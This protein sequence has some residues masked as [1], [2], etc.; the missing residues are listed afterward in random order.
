MDINNVTEVS[1]VETVVAQIFD[2]DVTIST[3]INYGAD[4]TDYME[5]SDGV[6]IHNS[7]SVWVKTFGSDDDVKVENFSNT[8]DAEAYGVVGGVDSK[9][10]TYDNGVKAAYGVY[11]AYVG[12]KQKYN[13]SKIEQKSG[14]LGVSAAFRKSNLFSNFTLNGGYITSE[15]NTEWGKDKFDTKVVS[16]ANKT[17]VDIKTY[18]NWKITPS[19]YVAYTGM[20]TEDYTNKAGVKMENEFSN[21]ITIAPEL[22]AS[23][24]IGKDLDG[25]A[26]VSYKHYIYDAEVRADDVLLEEMSAKPYVEYGFGVEKN[27]ADKS[28]Y[29]EITRRSG[30]RTGWNINLG[31][32]FDF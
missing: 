6:N 16:V 12:G 14:Y 3:D 2:R 26:K 18:N 28:G 21:V 31:L 8:I 24:R 5:T 9:V 15:A 1:T 7:K 25:Y 11:G 13:D 4:T 17:G 19:L 20:D 32:N 10:F 30:G 23:N 22:K 27:W 29:A